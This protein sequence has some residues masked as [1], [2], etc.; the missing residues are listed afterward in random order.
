MKVIISL[1]GSLFG[2]VLTMGCGRPEC[3]EVAKPAPIMEQP[4]PS[5]VTPYR[6]GIAQ[7]NR[8]L[9]LL[10]PGR[11]YL[12]EAPNSKSLPGY[13][14]QVGDETGYLFFTDGVDFCRDETK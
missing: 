5:Y 4:W 10:Q 1:L 11:Y 14:V 12:K 7:S 2:V 6:N 9:G 8:V 3:I 13:L